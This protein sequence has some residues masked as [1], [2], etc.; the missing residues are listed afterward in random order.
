MLPADVHEIDIASSI[1]GSPEKSLLYIPEG[2]G[3]FPLVVCLHTWSYDRF[4]QLDATLPYCRERGW[5]LLL[6]EFRG[7]N[8]VSNPRVRQA[9]GSRL[10]ISDILDA[11][12][13]VSAR[14]AVDEQAIFLLGGSGGGH[15]A[16][17]AAAE[18][19]ELWRGASVWV[20]ITDLA[21]WHEENPDYALN[22]AACCGGAP[23]YSVEVD[24]EYRLRS[25]IAKVEAL[26]KV[27]LSVHHGRHDE[28]VSW[29]HSW[30]LAEALH[31]SGAESFFFEIFDGGHE[32]RHATSF[33]WFDRLAGT[34][35]TVNRLTG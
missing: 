12:A 30:N 1:D 24:R 2:D 23:G 7:P 10:A 32:I 19:P 21:V 4:N 35:V 31:R 33:A 26:A 18:A 27:N 8:L 22:I 6:P 28:V 11:T 13:A 20:P 34:G 15:A 29:R 3:L 14:Y 5:G 9:G 17:L 25:P 16:L